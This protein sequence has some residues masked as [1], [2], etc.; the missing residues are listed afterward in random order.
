MR[1]FYSFAVFLLLSHFPAYPL[2]DLRIEGGFLYN[3]WPENESTQLLQVVTISEKS[4]S[5]HESPLRLIFCMDASQQMSG[6]PL[7][8]AKKSVIQSLSLLTNNDLLSVISYAGTP[9]VKVP[10]KQL[11]GN[12]RKIAERA[13]DLITYG[14]KRDLSL[15]IDKIEGQLAQSGTR[16]NAYTYINSYFKW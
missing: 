7:G 10:L 15:A 6:I 8:L 14:H 12:N 11:I 3:A 13:V 1:H 4:S 2:D 5:L 9:E 16:N